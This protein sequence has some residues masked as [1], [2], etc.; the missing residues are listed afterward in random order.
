M[1]KHARVVFGLAAGAILTA[2]AVSSQQS[3]RPAVS[4]A[5]ADRWL[6]ELS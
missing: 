5:Q 2:T 1:N 3:A 6:S 4:K